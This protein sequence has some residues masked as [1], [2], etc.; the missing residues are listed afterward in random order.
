MRRDPQLIRMLMLDLE[1]ATSTVTNS[2]IKIDGY[3][4]DEIKYH[5]NQIIDAGFAVG[6]VI[7]GQMGAVV[8]AVVVVSRLT[9]AGHDF[10]DSTRED[11]V[12]N[13]VTTKVTETGGGFTL[14]LLRQLA[15]KVLLAH[16]GL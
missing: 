5:L 1:L 11:T 7:H 16:V 14:D 2:N 10:I 6:N 4:D 8:P 15:L 3:T 13:A 9:S 12:W